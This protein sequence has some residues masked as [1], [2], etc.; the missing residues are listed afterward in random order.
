[1][2]QVAKKFKDIFND[3]VDA[4]LQGESLEDCLLRYPEHVEELE[5]LLRIVADTREVSHTIEPRPDFKAQLRYQTQ[6]RIAEKNSRAKDRYMTVGWL[7]RWATMTVISILMLVFAAGSVYAVSADTL[8]SFTLP[9]DYQRFTLFGTLDSSAVSF[10][11]P[12]ASS[13]VAN[14]VYADSIILIFVEPS[15]AVG[16]VSSIASKD[17]AV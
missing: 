12:A 13:T 3:C 4:M 14:F 10:A 1:M 5:P 17:T 15:A 2:I 7:P 16:T 8:A 11:R 9:A 6:S